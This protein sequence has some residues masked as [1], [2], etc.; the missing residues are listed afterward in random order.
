MKKILK[1]LVVLIGIQLL[2]SEHVDKQ[3]RD[4]IILVS[5][6]EISEISFL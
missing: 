2:N 4:R 6:Q 3:E 1:L 5:N